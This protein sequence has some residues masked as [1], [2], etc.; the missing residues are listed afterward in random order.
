MQQRMRAKPGWHIIDDKMVR[1]DSEME[2]RIIG[3]LVKH[4]FSGKWRR[5]RRGIA[6]GVSRSTPD[7]ELCILHD[8]M[9][10]R[11]LVELKAFS[12]TEFT[13]KDRERMRAASKF[14]GDAVCLLYIEKIRQWYF[15][16]PQGGLVKTAEPTPG[17]VSITQLPTPKIQ[18]PVWNRYGR[19]YFTRPSTLVIKKTADGLEFI[20]RSFF[21]SPGRRKK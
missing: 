6:F 12:A 1:T 19:S 17:G 8:G 3:R 11:A 21:Y 10:R 9:N 14:Y 18:I 4:G 16:E 2:A 13:R 20:I 7:L 5:M 15:I